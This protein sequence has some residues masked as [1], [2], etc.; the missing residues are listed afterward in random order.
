MWEPI[1]ADPLFNGRLDEFF[2]YNH[3]LSAV[4]IAELM[5][6]RPPP[7]RTPAAIS[8]ILSGNTLN[9]AWPN[10]HLGGRL[11]SNSVGNRL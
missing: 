4:E 6:N 8:G 5:N 3:A 1:E 7:P 11:E 10:S 2:V 9:L